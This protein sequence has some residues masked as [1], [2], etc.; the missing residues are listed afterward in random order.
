VDKAL[1]TSCPFD[2]EKLIVFPHKA[3]DGDVPLRLLKQPKPTF[4]L[5]TQ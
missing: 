3:R 1:I 2:L 4:I 5:E